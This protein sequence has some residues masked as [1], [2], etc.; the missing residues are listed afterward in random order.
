MKKIFLVFSI[1]SVASFARAQAV[2]F[3]DLKP[4][5]LIK[6][7][8][9]LS[10]EANA[11]PETAYVYQGMKPALTFTNYKELR[12]LAKESVLRLA[13]LNSTPD[14]QGTTTGGKL[15]FSET[16][17]NVYSARFVL[18]DKNLRPTRIE[19]DLAAK[20][21]PDDTI[22]GFEK[23]PED[24]VSL[25]QTLQFN[26][27]L[28]GDLLMNFKPEVFSD[29]TLPAS[30]KL[31]VIAIKK[32][33]HRFTLGS[34]YQITGKILNCPAVFKTQK[35]QVQISGDGYI[36]DQNWAHRILPS[37]VRMKEFLGM[38]IYY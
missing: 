33:H 9:D 30:S 32:K 35:C 1:L 18:L 21:S 38:Q 31:Q 13:S 24:F 8:R 12:A 3:A 27:V 23:Q 29:K 11:H 10:L 34:V 5:Q 19:F 20:A 17:M 37:N 15:S 4:R 36:R 6:I 7:N 16:G 25:N 14:F 28:L 26:R 2:K 22:D